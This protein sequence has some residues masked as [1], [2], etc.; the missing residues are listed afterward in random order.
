MTYTLG[1]PSDGQ[2]LGNSKIPIRTNFSDLFT[3][4]AKNHFDLNLTNGGKHRFI[5]IPNVASQVTVPD[6]SAMY[7]KSVGATPFA[8]MVWQQETVVGPGDP[9]RNKGAIVQMTGV[10]P[11]I[12]NPGYTFLPGGML[13]VWGKL[14]TATNTNSTVT[15]PQV[16]G[17]DPFSVI[18]YSIQLTFAQSTLLGNL[19]A[20]SVTTTGFIVHKV[21]LGTATI[22]FYYLAIGVSA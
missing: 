14:T 8:N 13:M 2:S 3:Y 21:G 6:T 17:A 22:D 5:E 1:V 9:S 4:L 11:L 18:P 16:N 7:G 15:F 19:Q 10:K 12:A 20:I